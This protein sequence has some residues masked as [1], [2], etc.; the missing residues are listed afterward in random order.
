MSGA[1]AEPPSRGLGWIGG[2]PRTIN[3]PTAL[4]EPDYQ[5][6]K[7]V[8]DVVRR[9][10]QNQL[11]A[12]HRRNLV[13]LIDML[14]VVARL[15]R[16]WGDEA[17]GTGSTALTIMGGLYN[18]LSSGRVWL[19]NTESYLKRRYGDTSTQ[20]ECFESAKHDA[21]DTHQGYR[22][23]Y[24][25]R[26]VLAHTDFPEFRMDFLLDDEPVIQPL[27]VNR[28]T[29]LANA[30]WKAKVR[31]DIAS[32]PETFDIVPLILD[33]FAGLQSVFMKST[34]NEL[35]SVEFRSGLRSAL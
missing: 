8:V 33:E 15:K 24:G 19:E 16:V 5:R 2:D 31:S 12:M 32:M 9:A 22:F 30:E 28:D 29:A 14:K 18:Y 26:N 20:V 23:V 10:T 34:I 25:L 21:F 3:I 27:L 17:L 11:W 13:T 35:G 4:E 1:S 7:T 6:A